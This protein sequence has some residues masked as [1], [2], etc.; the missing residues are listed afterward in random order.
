[1]LAAGDVFVPDVIA[2][3]VESSWLPIAIDRGAL[4]LPGGG[5]VGRR[6]G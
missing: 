1:M 4:S 3:V 5:K 6:G 2:G